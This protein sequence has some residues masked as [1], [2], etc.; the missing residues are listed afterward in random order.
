MKHRATTNR[1]SLRGGL[2]YGWWKGDAAA[3]ACLTVLGIGGGLLVAAALEVL[4]WP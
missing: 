3:W 1:P 4:T 2:P